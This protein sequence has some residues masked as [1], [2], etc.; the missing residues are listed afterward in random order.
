M[1]YFSFCSRN[2]SETLKNKETGFRKQENGL[3]IDK[4][5]SLPRSRRR[6]PTALTASYSTLCHPSPK[7]R[8]S[9]KLSAPPVSRSTLNLSGG[10]Y[11]QHFGYLPRSETRPG[12]IVPAYGN[13]RLYQSDRNIAASDN[14]CRNRKSTNGIFYTLP[15]QPRG[16]TRKL[17]GNIEEIRGKENSRHLIDFY[18]YCKM[19]RMFSLYQSQS[20]N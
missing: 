3:Y 18:F 6:T 4:N 9:A 10:N 12:A 17:S 8:A 13:S 16:K 14:E 2:Q 19:L 5:S 20:T 1:I 7:V 15:R 11:N